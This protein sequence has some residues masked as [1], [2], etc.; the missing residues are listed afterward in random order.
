VLLCLT[1]PRSGCGTQ[2]AALNEGSVQIASQLSRPNPAASVKVS[3]STP[4]RSSFLSNQSRGPKWSSP[5]RRVT[6]AENPLL[7]ARTLSTGYFVQPSNVYVW[8]LAESFSRKTFGF[9]RTHG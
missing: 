7:L 8:S 6:V 9:F 4:G 1:R 5:L 2:K 3:F